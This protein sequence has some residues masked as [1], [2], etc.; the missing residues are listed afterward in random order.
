MDCRPPGSSDHEILWARILE[1]VAIPFYRGSSWSRNQTQ[2]NLPV[3]QADSLLSAKLDSLFGSLAVSY[4]AM[5][6]LNI[7]YS[8]CA[9]L[10]DIYLNE[11]KAC[12]QKKNLHMN[13]LLLLFSPWAI[14]DSFGTP[15]TVALQVPLSM[16]LPRQEHWSGLPFPSP[17]DL[18]N[19]GIKSKSM[20]MFT[21]ALFTVVK[22][23]KQP[24]CPLVGK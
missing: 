19:P 9:L 15:W 12:S 3:M 16:K 4:K 23:W 20:W 22:N 1:Q 18:P 8:N 21:A 6:N 10:L 24:W 13:V 17:E 14:L 7:K 11:L 2:V 5:H